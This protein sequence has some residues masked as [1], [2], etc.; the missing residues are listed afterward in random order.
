LPFIALVIVCLGISFLV[1]SLYVFFRDLQYFYELVTF[2]LW[3]SSPVF[4]PTD[5]VPAAIQPF[6]KLNPILATIESIRQITLSTNAPSWHLIMVSFLTGLTMLV[7]GL[8]CFQK[9]KPQYMDLL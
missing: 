5:I 8:A 6:L 7:I 1:S 4:Y 3:I 2:L 9:F